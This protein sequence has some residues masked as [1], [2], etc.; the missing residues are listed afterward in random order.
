MNTSRRDKWKLDYVI[1]VKQHLYSPIKIGVICFLVLCNVKNSWM[2]IKRNL[3]IIQEIYRRITNVAWN[4]IWLKQQFYRVLSLTFTSSISCYFQ[5]IYYSIC[6]VFIRCKNLNVNIATCLVPAKG[7]QIE[8][9]VF[10]EWK[11]FT[12]NSLRNQVRVYRPGRFQLESWRNHCLYNVLNS[13]LS[14]LLF[15]QNKYRPS[16]ANLCKRLYSVLILLKRN[17]TH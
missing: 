14:K 1:I 2:S 7:K 12:P 10:F 17:T 11:R 4:K 9:R 8:V 13:R 15:T 5:F 6:I 16:K 3:Y